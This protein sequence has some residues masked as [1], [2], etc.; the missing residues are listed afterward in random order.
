M[1]STKHAA[2]RT[3]TIPTAALMSMAKEAL[4][5]VN[6]ATTLL[7]VE[8]LMKLTPSLHYT[9]A[10]VIRSA[11]CGAAANPKA[12]NISHAVAI[13]VQL[14][15]DLQQM[16]GEFGSRSSRAQTDTRLIRG[17]YNNRDLGLR[18]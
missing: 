17:E 8:D 11:Q 6:S 18:L 1:S 12:P 9:N 2:V 16:R 7:S 15:R 4:K 5:L 13:A 14:N 3:T 10:A